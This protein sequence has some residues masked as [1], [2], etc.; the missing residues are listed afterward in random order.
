M[1]ISAVA[2]IMATSMWAKGEKTSVTESHHF[3]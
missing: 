3:V 1:I 2:L